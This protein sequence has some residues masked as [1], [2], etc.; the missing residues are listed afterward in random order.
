MT[1]T[2]DVPPNEWLSANDRRGHWAAKAKRTK[3]LRARGA[4]AARQ[5]R[6]AVPTPVLV[7]A[8]IGYPRN[9]KADPNNASPTVKAILDG[10]TD[11][12]VWPDDDSEHVIGPLYRRGPKT[13]R[14]GWHTVTLTF[15]QQSIPF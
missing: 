11:A 14:Q 1:L 9:G 13:G 6:L 10:L 2:I 8:D 3:A 7:V 15:T 12:G 5:Q 4:W